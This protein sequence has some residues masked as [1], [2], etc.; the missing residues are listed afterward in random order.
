MNESSKTLSSRETEVMMGLIRGD[1]QLEIA[2]QMGVCRG[3]VSKFTD[4]I[5]LKLN[6][7]TMLQAAVIYALENGDE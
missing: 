3:T 2:D 1:N 6:A 4:R 5:K 7:T